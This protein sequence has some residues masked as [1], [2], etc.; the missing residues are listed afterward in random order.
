MVI[1]SDLWMKHASLQFS[2]G[3][4]QST[5][6][7]ANTYYMFVLHA[8]IFLSIRDNNYMIASLNDDFFHSHAL[9]HF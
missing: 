3:I 5:N 1:A 8:K 4:N 9:S 2:S 7:I 6:T